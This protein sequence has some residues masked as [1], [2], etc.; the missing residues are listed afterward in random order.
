MANIEQPLAQIRGDQAGAV[1]ILQKQVFAR[2][3]RLVAETLTP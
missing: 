2:I 1:V 3:D